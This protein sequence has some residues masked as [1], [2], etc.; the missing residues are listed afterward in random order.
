LDGALEGVASGLGVPY[1]AVFDALV[2][3]RAWRRA[4]ALGDGIHPT[5]DGYDALA[6]LV[7]AW[8]AW[9]KLLAAGGGG[10]A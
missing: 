4:L 6:D 7:A 3:D 2:S 5:G 9:Q 1:L 10:P 8:P